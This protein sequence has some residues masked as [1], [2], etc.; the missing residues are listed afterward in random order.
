MREPVTTL[1]ARDDAAR[2]EVLAEI[3]GG[4]DLLAWFGGHLPSFHDAEILS[5]E[6][7]RKGP[8]CRMRVHTWEIT[9]EVDEAGCF[10]LDRHVLVSFELGDVTELSLDGFNHQNVIFELFIERSGEGYRIE[11]ES[12]FG[13]SGAIAAKTV[14][15]ALEPGEPPAARSWTRSSARPLT[16]D[17]LDRIRRS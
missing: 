5:L 15:I 4:A 14:R 13:L 1:N 7:D 16:T 8:T 11:I 12:S 6:L 2:V 17:Q 10:V 9:E 3:P